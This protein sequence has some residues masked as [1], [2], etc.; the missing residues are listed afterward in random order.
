[1]TKSLSIDKLFDWY[2]ANNFSIDKILDFSNS[3]KKPAATCHYWNSRSVHPFVFRFLPKVLS[4]NLQIIKINL[5]TF[6]LSSL[7]TAF[8]REQACQLAHSMHRRRKGLHSLDFTPSPLSGASAA[9]TVSQ[10]TKQFSDSNVHSLMI[11]VI[12]ELITVDDFKTASRRR[13]SANGHNFA[14]LYNILVCSCSMY[15]KR[16]YSAKIW[17]LTI[18]HHK[19]DALYQH[20]M[21][22]CSTI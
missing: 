10:S 20:K 1:M 22:S 4:L 5:L 18:F 9:T 2:Q 6:T 7:A 13:S 16:M 3:P 14:N 19:V 8:L 11:W 17:M 21:T 15:L 12:D